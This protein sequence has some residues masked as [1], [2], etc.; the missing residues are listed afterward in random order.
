MGPHPGLLWDP[1][2]RTEH[3]L[4]GPHFENNLKRLVNE[5]RTTSEKAMGNGMQSV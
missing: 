3:A 1:T 2:D 4:V 5:G